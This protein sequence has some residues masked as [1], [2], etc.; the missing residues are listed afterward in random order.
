MFYW[1]RR[2]K[3][4]YKEKILSNWRYKLAA[5][6]AA[7]VVWSYVAGQQSMQAVFRVP[8]YF[9]N[10]AN[11]LE[12]NKPKILSIQVTVS[13]R[14][15]RMLSIKERQIW[16]SIDLAGMKVGR[17]VYNIKRADVVVPGGIEV[18]DYTPKKIIIIMQQ[19]KKEEPEKKA[20]PQPETNHT[21]KDDKQKKKK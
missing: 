4:F 10:L 11:D 14:R 12:M 5:L 17:N 8:I 18:K 1:Q 19:V 6:A 2:L 15:D 20:D 16:V 9:Q 3:K 7:F 13:G 21:E